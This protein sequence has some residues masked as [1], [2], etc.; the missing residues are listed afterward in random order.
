MLIDVCC[1]F[2]FFFYATATTEV[3]TYC[4]TLS[5]HGALPISRLPPDA[6]YWQTPVTGRRLLLADARYWHALGASAASTPWQ[7]TPLP[8]QPASIPTPRFSRV[9]GM[10]GTKMA[11]ITTPLGPS[12]NLCAPLMSAASAPLARPTASTA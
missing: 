6:C 4:H 1:R 3:Y 7:T 2:Y 5:L 12:L 10:G 9:I 8:T 11:S